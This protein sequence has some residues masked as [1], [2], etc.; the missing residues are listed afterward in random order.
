MKT[1]LTYDFGLTPFVKSGKLKIHLS[2]GISPY[3]ISGKRIEFKLNS[4][5]DSRLSCKLAS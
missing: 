4:M 3:N 2:I 1:K 5:S